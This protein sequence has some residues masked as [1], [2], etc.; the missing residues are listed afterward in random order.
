MTKQ[1]AQEGT[2]KRTLGLQETQYSLQGCHHSHRL[3]TFTQYQLGLVFSPS[4]LLKAIP[5]GG[6]EKLDKV[7]QRLSALGLF[8]RLDSCHKIRNLGQP[9][10]PLHFVPNQVNLETITDR[11]TLAAAIGPAAAWPLFVLRL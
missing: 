2:R 8:T 6:P 4:H 7:E 3:Q 10:P 1:L 9:S 5:P 11:L